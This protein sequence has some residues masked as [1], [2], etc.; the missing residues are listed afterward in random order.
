MATEIELK[1]LLTDSDVAE[2]L[3]HLLSQQ[4]IKFSQGIKTL[5]NTYFDSKDFVLRRHDIGLRIR[6]FDNGTKEQTIKLAGQVVGGL[7]S[8]PEYNVPIDSEYP[9]L[10]L[11]DDTIWPDNFAL[12]QVNSQLLPIFSTDFTRH[13]YH[14]HAADGSEIELV[15]DQ[16]KITSADKQRDIY[17]LEIELLSGDKQSLFDLA[18]LLFA[19]FNMRPGTLSKAARGYQ[20][21]SLYKQHRQQSKPS[22]TQRNVFDE[23]AQ[24]LRIDLTSD[25]PLLASFQFGMQQCLQHIQQLTAKCINDPQLDKLK[26]ISDTLALARHGIWLYSDYL[27]SHASEQLRQQIKAILTELSWVKTASQ[28]KELTARKGNYRKKIENSEELLATLKEQRHQLMQKKQIKSLLQSERFNNLQLSVLAISIEDLPE[29]ENCPQLMDLAPSWLSINLAT[30]QQNMPIDKPFSAT[31][32]IN[33]HQHVVYSLL[34]GSWFGRLYNIDERRQFRG[35]W[36]D[37]HHGIDELETL[38][39]LM[40]Y[41][42]QH[43][44]GSHAKLVGWLNDKID[45]LLV[46]LEHTRKAAFTVKPYWM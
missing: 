16:G 20:L 3:S 35:P 2:R 5:T 40:H 24:N 14:I 31:D 1:Y 12:E 30:L 6:S 19:H 36:L 28:I 37:I 39:F 18:R 29:P 11:F 34:T 32:Y 7:H 38:Y 10:T 13:F 26:S 15:F 9:D 45:S 21:S 46:A 23:Q 44:F 25:Q 42:Q 33:N 43:H 22:E 4:Q 27:P 17:E 41:L 8:R